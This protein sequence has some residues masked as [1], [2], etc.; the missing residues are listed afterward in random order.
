M[1]TNKISQELLAQGWTKD[2]TPEG[3]QKWNDFYGGWIYLERVYRGFTFVTPCGLLLKGMKVMNDVHYLCTWSVENDNAVINCPY[4]SLPE[5]PVRHPLL[6][7]HGYNLISGGGNYKLC[8]VSRT[9]QNWDYQNSL[10]KALDENAAEEELLW[11]AFSKRHRGRVCRYHAIFNRSEKR[12]HIHYDPME[13]AGFHC[14]YCTILQKSISPKMANVYYDLKKT[15]VERGEG[16]LADE[17]RVSITKGIKLVRA[18]ETICEVIVKVCRAEI[19]DRVETN[20]HS[21]CFFGGTVEVLNLRVD[22]RPTRDLRQDLQDVANGIAVVHQSDVNKAQ[23]TAKRQRRAAARERQVRRLEKLIC[24]SGFEGLSP[25]EQRRAQ[26]HLTPEEI[27]DAQQRHLALLLPME[28][29]PQITLFWE[30]ESP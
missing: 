27:E 11:A 18:S 13:C 5:C 25:L 8:S 17:A 7:R 20:H 30:V 16:F 24:T 14:D 19:Q 3:F 29:D 9:D 22:R 12:W 23:K 2:Q 6:Q 21:F 15:W 26:K 28:P 1:E 4:F 10:E